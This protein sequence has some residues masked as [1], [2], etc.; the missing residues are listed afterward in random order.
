MFLNLVANGGFFSF[1]ADGTLLTGV[2]G[3][4]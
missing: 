2:L 1:K 4:K 3:Y